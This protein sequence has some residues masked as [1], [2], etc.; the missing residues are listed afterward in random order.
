MSH[1]ILFYFTECGNN[2]ISIYI[3]HIRGYSQ[4]MSCI[5]QGGG[6]QDGESSHFQWLFLLKPSLSNILTLI[7]LLTFIALLTKDNILENYRLGECIGQTGRL[8]WPCFIHMFS[9]KG[10]LNKQYSSRHGHCRV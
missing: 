5:K 10:A 4:I 2:I 9:S 3:F 7:K 8:S 6:C 1:I